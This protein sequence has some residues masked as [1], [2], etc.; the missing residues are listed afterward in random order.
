[1][2]RLRVM[3]GGKESL[4]THMDDLRMIDS[5]LNSDGRRSSRGSGYRSE[6]GHHSGPREEFRG[7]CAAGATTSKVVCLQEENDA[8]RLGDSA[9]SSMES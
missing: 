5:P 8:L 4:S 3:R 1:M 9:S 6:V 7:L 2:S